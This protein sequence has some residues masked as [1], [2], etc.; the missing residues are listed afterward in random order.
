MMSNF[1]QTSLLIWNWLLRMPFR[2]QAC[3]LS[4]RKM[5]RENL[6]KSLKKL[7]WKP[8]AHRIQL[9]TMK[10]IDFMRSWRLSIF[11]HKRCKTER[12]LRN[13]S[14]LSVKKQAISFWT[15][16]FHESKDLQSTLYSS[17]SLLIVV[18]LTSSWSI[19]WRLNRRESTTM[20]FFPQWFVK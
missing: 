3:L 4:A 7:C 9:Q 16:Q 5:S 6:C 15:W 17:L 19:C 11:M 13:I 18:D 8:F 2:R 1:T 12:D 20:K 14:R 10:S